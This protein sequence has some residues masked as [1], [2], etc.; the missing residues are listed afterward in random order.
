[1]FTGNP[2]VG[3]THAVVYLTHRSLDYGFNVLA[4]ICMFKKKNIPEAKRRRW[5]YKD[6]NYLDIPDNFQ[7][8]PLASELIIKASQGENNIVVIDEAGITASSSKALSNTSVQM[9]YLGM[10][11]RKIG[12][13]LIIIAQDEDTVV[14]LLRSKIVTYKGEVIEQ[15]DG[16]RDLQ[17][18]KTQKYYNEQKGRV[19]VKFV[20]HGPPIINVPRVH[21]PYDT[22]HPGGFIFDINLENLYQTI[23]KTGYDAVEIRDHI[24][25]IVRDMVADYKI[26]EFMKR[27]K[28]MRT[29][30]VA[31]LLQVTDRTIRNWVE[32]GKLNAIRDGHGHYLF[33]RSEVKKYAL[34]QGIL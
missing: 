20:K 21:L 1:M 19:D 26:D 33:S 17:F 3:K 32:E 6:V 27:K 11:I 30:S 13:C 34:E 5:L 4:N 7:Y 18:Y 22:Q 28:F 25:S 10:S 15:D 8:V 24:E 16:R 31:E 29:G 2:G 23:A 9:K 14:P 12:A